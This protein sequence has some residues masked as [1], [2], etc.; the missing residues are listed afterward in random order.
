[1]ISLPAHVMF[2]LEYLAMSYKFRFILKLQESKRVYGEQ[3]NE[4]TEY[5]SLRQ[6]DHKKVHQKIA[7]LPVE[8]LK[9]LVGGFAS[10]VCL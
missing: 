2:D 8:I 7:R 9:E 5:Q 3:E 4:A 6:A 1:M 10:F